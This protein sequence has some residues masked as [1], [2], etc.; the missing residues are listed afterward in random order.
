M[1]SI[2][3]LGEEEWRA[4]RD[5]RL[6]VLGD[7]PDSFGST[8]DRER[9]RSDDEWAARVSAGANS[10]SDLPLVVQ[11][12]TGLVGLAWGKILPAAPATRTRRTS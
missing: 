12:H 10:E 4:Y 3:R 8:L 2:R 5:L 6:R 7:A 11:E 9:G 1:V